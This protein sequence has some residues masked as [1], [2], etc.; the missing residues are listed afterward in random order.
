MTKSEKLR[1]KRISESLLA[2]H[3][4]I[5]LAAVR[6]SRAAKKGAKT[7]RLMKELV[8]KATAHKPVKTPKAKVKV[9]PPK[10]VVEP[11]KVKA[12]KPKATVHKSVKPPKKAT[13]SKRKASPAK[14]APEVLKPVVL[15]EF[16]KK[17]VKREKVKKKVEKVKPEVTLVEEGPTEKK[18]SFSEDVEEEANDTWKGPWKEGEPTQKEIGYA[19]DEIFR[20]SEEIANGMGSDDVAERLGI[21]YAVRAW[22]LTPSINSD[23]T[24]SGQI[25]IEVP[26]GIELLELAQELQKYMPE[27]LIGN[28]Y[29]TPVVVFMPRGSAGDDA[30]MAIATSPFEAVDGNANLNMHAMKY[31]DKPGLHTFLAIAKGSELTD[32]IDPQGRF[33]L[34][35]EIRLKLRFSERPPRTA[36]EIRKMEEASQRREQ[37]KKYVRAKGFTPLGDL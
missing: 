2:Y 10:V 13:F 21:K 26:K 36:Y 19:Y 6:R 22:A 24:V 32:K 17:K 4:E 16:Q 15:P 31:R 3:E 18:E 14:P 34:P 1:R 37:L 29:I 35:K 23:K 9:K 28:L 33:I 5:R 11:P 27:P 20:L 30:L 8:A 25:R 12:K 7:K